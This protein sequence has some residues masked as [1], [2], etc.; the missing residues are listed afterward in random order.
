MDMHLSR[1]KGERLRRLKE[2]HGYGEKLLLEHIW[3]PVVGSFEHLH[4]E[5]E[6]VDEDGNYYYLDFAYLRDPGPT[7]L[8]SDGFNPHARDADRN[9]FKK[10]RRRQNA[11]ALK[12]WN[13][14]RFSTDDIREDPEHCRRTLRRMLERWYG[15]ESADWKG[16]SVY[17]KEILRFAIRAAKPITPADAMDTTGL[18]NKH[19]RKILREMVDLRLLEPASGEQRWTRYKIKKITELCSVI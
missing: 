17:Q 13:I 7:D 18:S 3:R 12:G 10:E 11:I 5:Y 4:P 1:R 19:V 16:L 9:S 8:E 6:V 15:E 2:G 14:L